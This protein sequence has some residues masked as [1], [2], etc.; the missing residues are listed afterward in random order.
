M[1]EFDGKETNNKE[2]KVNATPIIIGG[3]VTVLAGGAV[4][5]GVGTNW[6][7]GS[8]DNVE[9]A[10]EDT[11]DILSVDGIDDVSGIDSDDPGQLST[12]NTNNV[13]GTTTQ[14]ANSSGNVQVDPPDVVLNGFATYSW[15]NG[16]GLWTDETQDQ[17]L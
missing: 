3:I 2:R 16:G 13:G 12:N 14:N 6:G 9:M 5:A 10:I 4:Y 7:R 8:V 11:E 15:D 1:N 17:G